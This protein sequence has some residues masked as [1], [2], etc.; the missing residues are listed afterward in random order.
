MVVG[1]CSF[2]DGG[3]A[4]GWYPVGVDGAGRVVSQFSACSV[5]VAST[6]AVV[7]KYSVHAVISHVSLFSTPE[8]CW[9]ISVA[10]RVW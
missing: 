7:A 8:T 10:G 6:I 2:K 4:V 9:S 1:F 3:V 5:T